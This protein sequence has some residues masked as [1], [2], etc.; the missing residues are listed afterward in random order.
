MAEPTAPKP[1][2]VL[3]RVLSD[4]QTSQRKI[5]ALETVEADGGALADHL[6]HG[7]AGDG[8]FL[9]VLD[10]QAGEVSTLNTSMTAT[11]AELSVV[12]AAGQSVDL[13]FQ[14]NCKVNNG[15]GTWYITVNDVVVFWW[16]SN[17]TSY[18]PACFPYVHYNPG[19]G[20]YSYEIQYLA[21]SGSGY[22]AYVKLATIRGRII[23]I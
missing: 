22:R 8:D 5:A 6:H 10:H 21:G 12:V 4:L 17:V 3:G 7:V 9:D 20:T 23:G 11:G 13:L 14:F 16:S 1:L 18:W 2:A 19:A 15:T